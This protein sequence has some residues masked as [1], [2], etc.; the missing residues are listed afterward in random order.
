RLSTKC[1]S[2]RIRRLFGRPRCLDTS[3]DLL[4]ELVVLER[5]G[6]MRREGED[7][8]LV[9]WALFEPDAARDD[10]PEDLLPEDLVDVVADVP[11]EDRPLVVNGDHDAQE[12]ERRIGSRPDLLDGLEE[13]VGSLEREI[14]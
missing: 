14:G 3:D 1:W 8:F 11:P 9:G 6:G 5:P 2:C 12:L 7:R 10:G 4:G 13:V